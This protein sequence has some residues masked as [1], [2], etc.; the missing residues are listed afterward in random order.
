MPTF[1]YWNWLGYFFGWV[2]NLDL[3]EGICAMVLEN[4]FEE[5]K[6]ASMVSVLK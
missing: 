4:E 1:L 3:V 5:R 2:R 6:Q